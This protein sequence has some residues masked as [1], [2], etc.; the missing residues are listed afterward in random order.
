[1]FE[2]R[3]A[4]DG[5]QLHELNLRV[6]FERPFLGGMVQDHPLAGPVDITD[7]GFTNIHGVFE[8]SI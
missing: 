4:E 7:N 1:L 2:H 6:A 5:A 8:F 3:E